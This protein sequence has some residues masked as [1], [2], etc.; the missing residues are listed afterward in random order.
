MSRVV[1]IGEGLLS[2]SDRPERK[3]DKETRPTFR[4][5][6]TEQITDNTS[7]LFM[8]LRTHL[9][10]SDPG[11]ETVHFGARRCERGR[12][13]RVFDVSVVQVGVKM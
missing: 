1:D 4:E 13:I 2:A 3:P 12:R 8:R 9:H 6:D 5:E 10:P 7:S 11:S